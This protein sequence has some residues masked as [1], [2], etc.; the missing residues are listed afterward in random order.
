MDKQAAV[1]FTDGSILKRF[2]APKILNAAFTPEGKTRAKTAAKR[3]LTK[4]ET[5]VLEIFA[6]QEDKI[7]AAG[8]TWPKQLTVQA[9]TKLQSEIQKKHPKE[10]DAPD[11]IVD[12]YS[13][14]VQVLNALKGPMAYAFKEKNFDADYKKVLKFFDIKQASELEQSWGRYLVK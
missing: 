1:V 4:Q 2:L 12:L 6:Q 5:R 3:R 11:D 7:K 14:V 8:F 13:I 10:K 9:V